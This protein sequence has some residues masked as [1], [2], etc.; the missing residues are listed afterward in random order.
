MIQYSYKGLMEKYNSKTG[1]EWMKK[2]IQ[3]R[4]FQLLQDVVLKNLF[5]ASP[6][7]PMKF[8]I[9]TCGFH[10]QENKFL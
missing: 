4:C 6:Y 8:W 1:W 7:I 2:E 10:T 9:Q 3:V 5:P